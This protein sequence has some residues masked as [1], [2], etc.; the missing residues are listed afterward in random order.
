MIIKLLKICIGALFIVFSFNVNAGSYFG[1]GLGN[2]SWDI[3]DQG[4]FNLEDSTAIRLFGGIKNDNIGFEAEFSFA[5]YDWEGFG[6]Q[7]THN[8]SNLAFF[9]LYYVPISEGFEFF[10]KLGLNLWSTDVDFFGANFEGDDGVDIA[11]G[12]GVDVSASD[13]IKFRVEY[14]AFAGLGD[15]VDEGDVTQLMFNIVYFYQ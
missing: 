6:G 12:F 15:G 4:L 1:A 2:S 7:N 5:G 3:T 10:G 9:G 8:A 13:T 14:D 11:Y